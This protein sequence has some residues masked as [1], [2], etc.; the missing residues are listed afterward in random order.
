MLVN[1]E[2]S[3][4]QFSSASSC[5]ACITNTSCTLLQLDSS[6]PD[7]CP[8]TVSRRRNGKSTTNL[9]QTNIRK[10]EFPCKAQ[11]AATFAT[12]IPADRHRARFLVR[13]VAK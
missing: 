7:F 3:V 11:Y 4:E 8:I 13:L 6:A 1:A 2:D 12:F 5:E 10:S 9:S